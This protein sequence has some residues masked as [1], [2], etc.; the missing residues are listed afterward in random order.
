VKDPAKPKA[1]NV[2]ENYTKHTVRE[3]P[4]VKKPPEK[5]LRFYIDTYTSTSSATMPKLLSIVQ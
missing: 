1:K 3:I 5:S 4:G 2:H